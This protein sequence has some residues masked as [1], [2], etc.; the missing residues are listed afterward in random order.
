LF[1]EFLISVSSFTDR[2]TVRENVLDATYRRYYAELR[3]PDY[4]RFARKA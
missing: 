3:E 2:N 1:I 4:Y